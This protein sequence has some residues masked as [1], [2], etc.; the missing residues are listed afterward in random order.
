MK[1]T[2]EY[3]PILNTKRVT[4][5]LFQD[6]DQF[7]HVLFFHYNVSFWSKQTCNLNQLKD[8]QSFK[9]LSINTYS[10]LQ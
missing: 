7:Q 3:I 5:T 1:N 9:A 4:F 6:F 8:G 10:S 2:I